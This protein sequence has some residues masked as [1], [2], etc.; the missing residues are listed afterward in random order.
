[1]RNFLFIFIACLWSFLGFGQEDKTRIHRLA[2]HP[3]STVTINGK[4]NVNKYK[5]TIDK[6]KGSD[7]LLLMAEQGKGAYF[8][9]GLVKLQTSAFECNMKAITKDFAKT[10]QSDKYPYIEINFISFEREPKYEATEEK[11]KGDITITLAGVT[12]PCELR[13]SIVK[14]AKGLIHLQGQHGFN[15][16]DFNLKAPSRVMGMV[17]VDEKII[18]NFHLVLIKL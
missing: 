2:I 16:S 11:F 1:M 18:V 10:I 4:T 14:D 15:F 12:V 13:C 3:S 5:C 17:K 7:T 9:K 6:Y 8:K